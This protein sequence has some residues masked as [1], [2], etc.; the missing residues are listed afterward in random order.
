MP[1]IADK[2]KLLPDSAD[3]RTPRI[4]SQGEPGPAHPRRWC[5]FAGLTLTV[6]ALTTGCH[7][8]K[9]QPYAPPPP[10]LRTQSYNRG[11]EPNATHA[12]P[13]E[14][15]RDR[16]P[17][18]TP[19]GH[20]AF[21]ETGMASWYGPSGH[22]AAD[23]SAYDG[24]GMTAAHK[25][26]PLGTI[27]RVTNLSNGESVTV[28]ITDRGPF[29]NGR[30]LDLSESAAKK[31]DLYRMGIAQ[32]RIE[33]FASAAASVEG[34]WCVQTGAF[35]TEQDALDLKAALARRYAGSRVIEFSGATGYW[36]RIDPLR[37]DRTE[38]ASIMAWIGS[39][40]PQ[41]VPYLVRLN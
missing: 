9:R 15:L 16:E 30:I 36:V 26:L 32:V 22:R 11:V 37:H 33:A 34:K 5:T 31:I 38:A 8:Q 39:P 40:L 7:H 41:V 1:S 3:R 28:R 18:P 24:T 12:G 2:D 14:T 21:V 25:T 27:A 29:S 17:I 35:K 20:P 13:D 23:G 4:A 19:E 6:L 10:P